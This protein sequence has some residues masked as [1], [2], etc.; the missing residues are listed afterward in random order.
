MALT[1]HMFIKLCL[2]KIKNGLFMLEINAIFKKFLSFLYVQ[3]FF[4][5]NCTYLVLEVLNWNLIKKNIVYDSALL[6]VDVE[7]AV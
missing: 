1:K 4:L 6:L 5:A 3:R 7:F 2:N